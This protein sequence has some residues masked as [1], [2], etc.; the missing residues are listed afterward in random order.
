MYTYIY[1]YIHT[2]I[3]LDG[4]RLSAA[5]SWAFRDVVF[6]DVGFENNRFKATHPCNI[7]FRCEV[8][9]PSVF[10]G[11]QTTYCFQTPHPQTPNP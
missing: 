3:P 9:T 4:G 11:Q 8:R 10:E 1:I 7:S 5:D 6:E 2:Y